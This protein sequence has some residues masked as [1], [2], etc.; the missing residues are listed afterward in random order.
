MAA[1]LLVLVL[2]VL[3]LTVVFIVTELRCLVVLVIL[4]LHLLTYGL[5]YNKLLLRLLISFVWLFIFF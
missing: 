3:M 1:M 4:P 5:I 2:L